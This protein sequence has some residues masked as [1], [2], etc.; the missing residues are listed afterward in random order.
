VVVADS[1]E[2]SWRWHDGITYFRVLIAENTEA[3]AAVQKTTAQALLINKQSYEHKF[4]DKISV[5]YAFEFEL[6]NWWRLKGNN[7][8]DGERPSL[9]KFDVS[10]KQLPLKV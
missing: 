2:L 7:I 5:K 6:E 4:K 8:L 9:G 1:D 10:V 3:D